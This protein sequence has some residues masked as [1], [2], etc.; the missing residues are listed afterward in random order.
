MTRLLARDLALA[1][2]GRRILDGVSLT[3]ESGTLTGL[4]GPNGAGKT[5]LMRVL[6]GLLR[7]SAGGVS[8]DGT[9]LSRFTRSAL[10]RHIAYMPQDTTLA[11]PV[12]V[13]EVVA[14]GRLPFRRPFA[15]LDEADRAA[16]AGALEAA[17]VTNLAFRAAT[18]LSAG[19][20][21]RV[22]LARALAGDTPVLLADEPIAALD[23]YHQLQVMELLRARAKRGVA[24]LVVLH[25]LT[26]AARFCG[27]LLLLAEGRVC[28]DG[29]AENV[30]SDA[31]LAQAFAVESLIGVHEGEPYVLPWRRRAPDA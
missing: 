13:R 17:D 7:P 5:T 29:P 31:A 9:A 26:L 6:A 1:L 10:A 4:V 2:N 14:L 12:A 24:V 22:L 27:R 3:V 19:E 21:T 15:A 30:A 28:A 8:L 23:P 25:D 11:W 20:R 16:I 18:A